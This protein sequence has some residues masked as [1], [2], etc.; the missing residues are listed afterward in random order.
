MMV[1][2]QARSD[3]TEV[4]KQHGAVLQAL[5]KLFELEV[6]ARAG[7]PVL[8]LVS[9]AIEAIDRDPAGEGLRAFLV[10]RGWDIWAM[11]GELGLFGAMRAVMATRPQRQMW[12][13]TVLSGLWAD[14]GVPERKG[15]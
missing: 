2:A 13:R 8:R 6:A 9:P 14:I 1:P 5:D 12:N 11:H 4:D 3:R 7:R 10:R 15:A